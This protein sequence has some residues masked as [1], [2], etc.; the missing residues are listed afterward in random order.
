[1]EGEGFSEEVELELDFEYCVRLR[2]LPRKGA[3]FQG[4]VGIVW[5][6]AGGGGGHGVIKQG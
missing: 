3:G 1:M 6:K 5:E 4:W 2:F